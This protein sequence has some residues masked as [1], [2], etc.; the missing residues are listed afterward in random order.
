MSAVDDP[1][2]RD[3]ALRKSAESI[4]A[5]RRF[6]DEQTDALVACARSMAAAFDAGGRL[7]AFGNGGS[8]CDAEHAAVEFMHPIFAKRPALPAMALTTDSALL[9]AIGN[10]D[11]F[12]LGFVK[13]LRLLGRT[14]DVALGISTSGKSANVLRALGAA[15]EMGM[16]TVGFTGAG[17][18]K[19]SA[20][21]DHCF[22][23]PSYAIHRVQEVH[24]AILHVLWD[25][26]HLARGEDD[27]L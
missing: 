17:G 11:D 27:V 10:D 5:Q 12:A 14:G 9:T 23:V 16:L 13:Q 3:A 6:F 1:T 7:I 26:V 24:T 20:A 22:M 2:L 19:L 8:A 21:C 4:A 18:G 25:L 15:R